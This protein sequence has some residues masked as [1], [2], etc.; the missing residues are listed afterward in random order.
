MDTD[1]PVDITIALTLALSI[2]GLFAYWY[3]LVWRFFHIAL[4]ESGLHAF[5]YTELG[6]VFLILGLYITFKVVKQD[7]VFTMKTLRGE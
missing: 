4:V 5:M 7:L 1:M 6:D 3:F 2:A